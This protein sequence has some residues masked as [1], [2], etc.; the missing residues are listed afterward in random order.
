MRHLISSVAF[1][2]LGASVSQIYHFR[3]TLGNTYVER[4]TDISLRGGTIISQIVGHGDS[5]SSTSDS[6]TDTVY[7]PAPA[8]QYVLNHLDELGYDQNPASGCN[9]W[10]NS[11]FPFYHGLQQYLRE[12]ED[13]YSLIGNFSQVTPDVRR[14]VHK[15]DSD[16]NVCD[17]LELHPEGLSGIFPS[18]QLS[19][20]GDSFLEPAL[21]PMRHPKWCLPPDL[22][23]NRNYRKYLIDI[24]YLVHD[25]AQLCRS[26]VNTPT[27]ASSPRTVLIDMGASLVF[28]FHKEET[29]VLDLLQLYAKFG[30]HFDHYYAYELKPHDPNQVFQKVPQE[31]LASYH[32]MNVGVETDRQSK[33]NPWK[34]LKENFQ[35]D[36]FIVVKLDIDKTSIELELVDQLL[37][38]EHLVKL[39]DQFY[40]EH[41]VSL[42]EWWPYEETAK[43]SLELFHKLRRKGIAAHYWV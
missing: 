39:V 15:K 30:I 17:L 8:E 29:P 28:D 22:Q 41:H 24:S 11:S 1:F 5:S 27:S 6:A 12:L 42:T 38:D 14:P 32:W 40:F 25:F 36:D 10:R 16:V 21:P 4:R 23:K 33:L 37:E 3:A 35:P 18:G 13:Y 20:I 9:V 43:K 2:C 7:E 34:L 19:K 26:I 31:F